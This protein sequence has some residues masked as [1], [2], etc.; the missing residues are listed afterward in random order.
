MS[1]MA[2][3]TRP[4]RGLGQER[5]PG[6]SSSPRSP[7]GG[8]LF[9]A[10]KERVARKM[11]SARRGQYPPNDGTRCSAFIGV[12]HGLNTPSSAAFRFFFFSAHARFS[13]GEFPFAYLTEPPSMWYTRSH[14]RILLPR[15]SPID[16]GRSSQ[17]NVVGGT[18]LYLEPKGDPNW[19][20][21]N[22]C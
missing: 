4:T 22:S 15:P 14:E 12:A 6:E 18:Y 7:V 19:P 20:S 5:I 3:A 1:S 17:A 8:W 10:K 21:K 13:P 11:R 2:L 9:V 16:E